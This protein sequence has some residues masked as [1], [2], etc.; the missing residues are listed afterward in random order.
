MNRKVIFVFFSM[1]CLIRASS[2]AVSP[3][4]VGDEPSYRLGGHLE[5]LLDATREMTLSQV[6]EDHADWRS[7]Q[8]EEP[9]TGF[10]AAVC[11][12]RFPLESRTD[13]RLL[14][15]FRYADVNYVD[16]FVLHPNGLQEHFTSG[17]RVPFNGRAI[18]HRYPVFPLN[19]ARG[20]TVQCYLQVRDEQGAIIPL[21]VWSE[22]FFRASDLG[23]Q[24][25]IGMLIGLFLVVL[26]FNA[27]FFFATGD[28]A[29]LLYVA[30]VLFYFIFELAYRGIGGEYL[31]PRHTWI[32]DPVLVSAASLA[33]TAGLVFTREFLGTKTWAPRMH[34]FLNVL[35]GVSLL[36]TLCTF[37]L[38]FRIMVQTT[39][40]LL[41]AGALVI[42]PN[43]VAVLRR[44]FRA[45]RFYLAAWIFLLAGSIIF[46]MLNLGLLPSNVW[47]QNALTFGA[48]LQVILISF[49]VVDRILILRR[50]SET[51]QRERLDAVEKGL[52]VDTLTDLPNRS[53]LM[54]DL[55]EDGPRTVIL[56][57]ID[58]FKEIND[59]FGQKAGD[60]VIVELGRRVRSVVT[61][62]G[63]TVYRLHADEFAGVIDGSSTEE[64]LNSLGR[65]L[66]ARCQNQP[67][68]YEN[69][70]LRLDVSV[71]LAVSD[72]RHLEKADMAMSVS[73]SSKSY[74]IYRPELVVIKRYADNL[75]WLRVI[76]E[77]LEHGRIIPFFQPILNNHSGEIDKFESLMRIRAENG[78]IIPPGAF[79][80]IAKKSKIYPELSRVI[81]GTTARLMH[82]VSEEVSI[83]VSVEDIVHPDVL[84][85]IDR[86]VA[87]SDIAHRIVFELLESEGIENYEE[88]SRFIER[89]KARG[90]KI[91]IDD[92][93]SGYSNFEHILRLRV[94]FLKLDASLIKP[95]AQDANARCIV[96][97]I[98]SFT[99]KL[100][101]QTIAEFV[102]DEAVHKTVREI[103]VDFSQGYFIGEP[104]PQMHAAHA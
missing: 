53:R 101:I 9:N 88:V 45:A 79:L 34:L 13:H 67:Y 42:V 71:G 18:P 66:L 104:R 16:L 68:I 28:R 38:P 43:A 96:E 4:V 98:V 64:T 52:Y 50:E 20:E 19:V 30:F 90:C 32:D 84:A 75:H 95:I 23:E 94:D 62:H 58:S 22:S 33:I 5:M 86:V 57:N 46:G 3:L 85:E 41:L 26:I 92:F 48:A 73:R 69:E 74:S 72:A 21:S 10:S 76:R 81:V 27:L 87:E 36:N 47:T 40:G 89:M 35:L 17:N 70:T 65:A 61:E 83:N 55:Q 59:Y 24:I 91:A 63:G 97:T 15:V 2:L 80:T 25:V 49:A 11:W 51:M 6:R 12:L 60:F 78:S 102:H 103:G 31:W 14:L 44:G 8:A 1:V 99:K 93:G 100:G 29:Y 77:S 82:E 54:S 37:F 7:T 39:N 56:V